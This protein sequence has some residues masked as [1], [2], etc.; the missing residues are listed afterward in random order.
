MSD[1]A[2]DPTAGQIALLAASSDTG[3]NVMVNLLRS[4]QVADPGY[5]EIVPHRTAGL[6]DSRL[7]LSKTS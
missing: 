3:P 4:G 7:I 5:Q 6:A 2:I 1:P